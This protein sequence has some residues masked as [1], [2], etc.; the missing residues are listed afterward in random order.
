VTRA[1]G[2][3][4]RPCI[5]GYFAKLDNI[6][7]TPSTVGLKQVINKN[8]NKV[9]MT[10]EFFLILQKKRTATSTIMPSNRNNN[11]VDKRFFCEA[12]RDTTR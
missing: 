1:H 11:Y 8:P 6:F 9:H 12:K 4:P 5:I 7:F 2:G 3:G 10:I